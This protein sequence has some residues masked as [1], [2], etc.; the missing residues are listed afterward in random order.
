MPCSCIAWTGQSDFTIAVPIAN[1][2]HTATETLVGTFINTLVL[3]INLEGQP[4]LREALRRIEAVAL[5]AYAHQDAPF[6][7]LAKE[8]PDARDNSRPPLAQVMFNLL[9]TPGDASHSL[10]RPGLQGPCD[11]SRSRTI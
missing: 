6:E 1:R 9:N 3:R 8:F 11:R 5:D 7:Q 4:T 2:T 10:G